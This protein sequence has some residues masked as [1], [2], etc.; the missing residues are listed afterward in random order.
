MANIKS[1]KK[2]ALT[3]AKANAKN[4]AERTE[5]KNA[6][7]N[8]LKAVEA[9]DADAAKAAYDKANSV[10]DKAVSSGIKKGNYA[11]RQKSRLA[12]AVNTI[13]Q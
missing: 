6:I 1:Q 5:V 4:S 3:N 10:L 9:K 11:S 7:K 8:V 2:R 12:K 13:G